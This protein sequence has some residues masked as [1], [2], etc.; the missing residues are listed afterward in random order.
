MGQSACFIYWKCSKVA[1][2]VVCLTTKFFLFLVVSSYKLILF[3]DK[4]SSF[5]VSRETFK[6]NKIFGLPTIAINEGLFCDRCVRWE[7]QLKY[8]TISRF[9]WKKIQ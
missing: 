5:I 3:L 9:I 1:E 6:L 4:I 8:F 2:K 7:D